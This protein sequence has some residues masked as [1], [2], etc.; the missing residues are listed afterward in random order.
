MIFFMGHGATFPPLLV[1]SPNKYIYFPI[2]NL[3][4]I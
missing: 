1:F 4:N 2:Q 3:L